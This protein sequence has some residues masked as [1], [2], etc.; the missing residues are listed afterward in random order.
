VTGAKQ[1]PGTRCQVPENGEERV[2]LRPPR[3]D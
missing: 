3:F 1:V 2:G